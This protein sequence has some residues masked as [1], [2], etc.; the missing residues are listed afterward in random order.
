MLKA[1][2]PSPPFFTGLTLVQISPHSLQQPRG[3]GKGAVGSSSHTVCATPSSSGGAALTLFPCSRVGPPM[4]DT[5]EYPRNSSTP[6][7]SQG[8][9]FHM[10]SPS[11]GPSRRV[12]PFRSSKPAA[13]WPSPSLGP[14]VLPGAAPGWSFHRVTDSF[15]HPPA[16]AWAPP[17]ASGVSL[18]PCGSPGAVGAQQPH[19]GLQHGNLCSGTWSSSWPSFLIDWSFQCCF[20]HVFSLLSPA[21]ALPPSLLGSALASPVS[22]SAAGI[23]SPG[24]RGIFWQCPTEATLEPL[25]AMHARYKIR[26]AKGQQEFDALSSSHHWCACVIEFSSCKMSKAEILQ[27]TVILFV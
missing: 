8:L 9:Q 6:S 14:Q 27:T 17:Q 25:L 15:G 10:N 21:A 23:S 24:H 20:S 1:H 18:F 19:H 16:P 22:L 3:R 26:V 12:Q 11:V 7:P 4:G 13:A 5:E 2:S